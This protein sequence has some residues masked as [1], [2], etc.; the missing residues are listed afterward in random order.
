MLLHIDANKVEATIRDENLDGGD[1]LFPHIYGP[2]PVEAVVSV[3]P[4]AQ[5]DAGRLLLR[6]QE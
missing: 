4:I 5:D 2:L 3:E 1:E 6:E